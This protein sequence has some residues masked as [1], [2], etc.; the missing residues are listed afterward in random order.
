VSS[1]SSSSSVDTWAGVIKLFFPSQ[2][3]FPPSLTFAGASKASRTN[4]LRVTPGA[5]V[6]K[7]F[8]P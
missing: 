1:S 8:C 3:T 7:L 5:N 2:L 6:I 4:V